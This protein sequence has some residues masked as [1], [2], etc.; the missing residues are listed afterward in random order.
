MGRVSARTGFASAF[1]R[2]TVA[3]ALLYAL[4]ACSNHPGDLKS[5]AHGAMAKLTVSAAPSAAPQTVFRDAAGAAHTLADFQGKVVVLN[6]W[7]NWCAPCKEEIPSLARLQKEFA[8]QPVAVVPVSIGKDRDEVLGKAF[9][10]RNPPL[11]FYT[12]PTANFPFAFKPPVEGMPTT[13]LF[14]R[15]GVERARLSGGADWSG[16]EARAVIRALLDQ[17]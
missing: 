7:A 13:V 12:E 2:A 4:T 3:A 8:G 5:L 9:L 10:A 11:T 1:L 14:D 15:H 6:L 16:P 17:K